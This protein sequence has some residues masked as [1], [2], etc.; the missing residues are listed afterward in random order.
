M[1]QSLRP[2]VQPTWAGAISSPPEEFDLTPLM[3]IAGE[4]PPGLRGSLYRNGPARL[5][6]NGQRVGH[7]FDGDGA[8]LGVHFDG[9]EAVATYRYVRSAGLKAEEV[10]GHYLYAGYGSLAPG[11][12]WQRWQ[13]QLKNVANTSVLALPERLLALWEGGFPHQLDPLTLATQGIDDLGDLQPNEPYSAHPKRHPRTGEIF[14]FGLVAGANAT[15]MLYRSDAKG[16]I[17]HKAAIPLNGIPLIHDFVLADRYLVFCVPPLR[18]NAFPAV[19]GL[20]SFSDSLAW[21]P[22]RGTQIVVVDAENFDVVAWQQVDPWFQWHFG[23]GCLDLDEIVFEAITYPDFATNSRLK[24]FASGEMHTEARGQLRQFRLDPRTG[25]I[26][27]QTTRLDR[28]CEL[29]VVPPGDPLLAPT[30]LVCDRPDRP[31]GQ[32]FNALARLDANGHLTVADM[33][34]QHYPSEPIWAADCQDLHR[35]W[36][37]SVVYD[38]E[39]DTSEI[40]IYDAEGLDGNPVCRLGLPQVIPH[41]FH[42]T[43]Q[44][45]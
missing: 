3:V 27:E 13:S 36:V 28:S 44:P 31:T 25:K 39:A 42:G 35:A 7:W 9:S 11:R 26:L 45:R 14:N 20:A 21:Q 6:R 16:R 29:P 2:S 17:R 24:E 38:G 8:V 18:L 10:A 12:I 37:L 23:R 43:W 4:L 19:V 34:P 1:I 40:W 41:S 15:L 30:F 32:L 22:K 33:G 5:E